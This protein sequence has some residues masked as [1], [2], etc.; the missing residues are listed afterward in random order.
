MNHCVTFDGLY[1][2]REYVAV[3]KINTGDGEHPDADGH[4]AIA[5][6]FLALV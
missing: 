2:M 5:Q 3:K 6:K 1:G 4:R